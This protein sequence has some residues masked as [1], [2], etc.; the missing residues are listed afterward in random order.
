MRNL[1]IKREKSAAARLCKMKVYIEDSQSNE[2]TISGV[3]CRKLGTLKSG[4]EKTF[5]VEERAAKVFV[6]ADKLSRNF[7]NEYYDLPEGAEDIR[8]VGEN[9]LDFASGNAFRFRNNDT[10][11]VVAHRKRVARKGA[12][13]Y[14]V[15]IVLGFIIGFTSVLGLFGKEKEKTFSASNMTI[16]LTD[17]FSK[18]D[19]VGYTAVFQSVDVLV[20]C[21]EEPFS[22][23]DDLSSLT[24]REYANQI[25]ALN[26]VTGASLKTE[27]G[28]TYFEYEKQVDGTQIYQYYTFVYKADIAFWIVQ[29]AVS[30]NKADKL[31]D[32]VFDWAQTVEFAK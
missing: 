26:G 13:V 12:V 31:R 3:P 25:I 22:L 10:E 8:L 18:K 9:R 30:E 24:L 11:E 7:S 23:L 29:F 2:L 27:D 1:T 19:V 6:I 15:A 28:L 32:D 16:T 5:E 20:F 21:I 17:E 4:E 14:V